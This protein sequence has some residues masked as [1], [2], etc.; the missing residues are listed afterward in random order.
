[1][2]WPRHTW[3]LPNT[4]WQTEG[5]TFRRSV[6]RCVIVREYVRDHPG[7]VSECQG[8]SASV[9]AYLL[10]DFRLTSLLVWDSPSFTPLHAHLIPFH[11]IHNPWLS[12]LYLNTS[13]N[14]ILTT[15]QGG[16]IFLSTCVCLNVFP[17]KLLHS[18]SLEMQQITFCGEIPKARIC[19]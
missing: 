2:S 5:N 12:S 10:C 9:A 17:L 13:G 16:V 8:S 1:M 19:R 4:V 3:T 14:R 11:A 7:W 18:R 15:S 6:F